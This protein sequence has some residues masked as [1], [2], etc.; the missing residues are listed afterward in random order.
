[1][2]LYNYVTFPSQS[3]EYFGS[4]QTAQASCLGASWSQMPGIGSGRDASSQLFP[5]GGQC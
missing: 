3:Q 4:H 5:A 1:M 2:M